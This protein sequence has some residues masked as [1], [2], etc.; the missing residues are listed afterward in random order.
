MG[1]AIC[2]G[3]VL[4]SSG[5]TEAH[6][7][8]GSIDGGDR[9]THERTVL[10]DTAWETDAYRVAGNESG[11]TALVFGGV[12]GD[13]INGYRVAESMLDWE[14]E[15][16][17]LVVVPHANPIAVKRNTRTGPEGDLNRQFPPGEEP[18]TEL[19]RALWELTTDTD[20]D[21]VLDL[22]RSRGILGT[23]NMWVG[24]TIFPTNAGDAVEHARAVI[25]QMNDE[26]VPWTMRSH[27]FR[28]GNVADGSSTPLIHKVA[29][30]LSRPG[31]LTE[32]TD[33]LL[34]PA[35]QRRWTTE[36]AERLLER[37][38]VTRS[39]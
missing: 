22:H 17:S 12:H 11:P 26:V 25:E 15:T 14:V 4:Q 8:D 38:G 18:T 30:E 28:L 39:K 31:Y 21:V 23:H 34:S 32:L 5:R 10:P 2:G 7:A 36:L 6:N 19:A 29:G 1:T 13:E 35:T 20:P 3:A 27:R 37:H 16:G 24:Q 9:A 33:F